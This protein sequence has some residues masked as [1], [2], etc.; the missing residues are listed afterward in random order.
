MNVPDP[1]YTMLFESPAFKEQEQEVD[2][3]HA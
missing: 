2:D 1:E 3:G